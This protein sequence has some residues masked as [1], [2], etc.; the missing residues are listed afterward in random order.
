M[1]NPDWVKTARAGD[2]VVCVEGSGAR[3]INGA[4]PI[5]KGAVYEIK[6]VFVVPPA[7]PQAGVVGIRLKNHNNG[8]FKGQEAGYR[9]SAFRP[10]KPLPTSLT[11]HLKEDA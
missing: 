9:A 10:V 3:T 4:S 7:E 6:N 1:N 8:I 11:E 2:F 5:V